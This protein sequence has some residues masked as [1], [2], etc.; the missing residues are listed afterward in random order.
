M[1]QKTI[2]PGATLFLSRDTQSG[3]THASSAAA[4]PLTYDIL[5]NEMHTLF[6]FVSM[7]SMLGVRDMFFSLLDRAPGGDILLYERDM[8]NCYW[9]MKKREVI[10]A[11][12]EAAQAVV[13]GR[14]VTG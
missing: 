8:D 9:E 13:E 7:L 1:R 5:M 2:L 3:H 11:I 4:C 10:D 12:S 14:G 6:P